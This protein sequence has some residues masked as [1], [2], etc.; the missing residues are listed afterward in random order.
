M[1]TETLNKA[2][3]KEQ[4]ADRMQELSEAIAQENMQRMRIRET[5]EYL[6]I[7]DEL[8]GV[9]SIIAEYQNDVL[10]LREKQRAIEET[11]PNSTPEF[12]Q[13]KGQLIQIMRAEGLESIG[14]VKAKYSKGKFVNGRQLLSAVGGDLDMFMTIATVT[15][16]AV[17]DFAKTISD[18][19]VAK[20][21]KACIQEKEP[22][23]TDVV[24]EVADIA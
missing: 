19:H 12:E 5:T 14:A 1:T 17:T 16:K 22:E 13:I 23:L 15:Q 3:T 8:E 20:Q 18:S 10:R 9:Q 2:L 4:L 6:D 21:I 7:Q 24:I 11:V